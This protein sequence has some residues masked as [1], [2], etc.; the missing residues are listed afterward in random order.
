VGDLV[1]LE[2]EHRKQ[3]R[4]NERLREELLEAKENLAK[5]EG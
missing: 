4:K 2:E 3:Q 1:R 5:M